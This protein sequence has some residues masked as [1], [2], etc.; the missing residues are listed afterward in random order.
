MAQKRFNIVN[1][2][3]EIHADLDSRYKPQV[4]KKKQEAKIL[5]EFFAEIDRIQYSYLMGKKQSG[6]GAVEQ[7]K[8]A[9]QNNHDKF[10]VDVAIDA[11][12]KSSIK[13]TFGKKA[14][15]SFD[16]LEA[17]MGKLIQSVVKKTVQENPPLRSIVTGKRLTAFEDF[18]LE[19][20]DERLKDKFLTTLATNMGKELESVKLRNNALAINN[21]AIKTDIGSLDITLDTTLT[22]T[23]VYQ[24]A[25]KLLGQSTFSLKNYSS[26]RDIELGATDEWKSFSSVLQQLGRSNKDIVRSY[27]IFNN[28]KNEKLKSQI[29]PHV[30]H[31]RF[32]YELSGFGQNLGDIRE[33]DFLV[34]NRPSSDKGVISSTGIYVKSTAELITTFLDRSNLTKQLRSFTLSQSA[35]R[36]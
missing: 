2:F 4:A 20:L 18:S 34:L 28:T 32:V 9:L 15:G 17:P 24:Q 10:M 27:V 33:A 16:N 29:I 30:N 19:G 5:N 6:K 22:L 8:T 14:K 11:L 7:I 12:G 13:T 31:I 35:M 25:V 1:F 36:E 3:N 26:E 21:R 23:P